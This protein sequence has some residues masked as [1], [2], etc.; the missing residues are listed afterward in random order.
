VHVA[1]FP[2]GQMPLYR[3]ADRL[4]AISRAVADAIVAQAP[5][6]ADRVVTIGYPVPDAY[7]CAEP[8]RQRTNTVLYVGRI[9]R[10][11]GLHVLVRAFAVAAAA[12]P[13][14]TDWKLRIIGPHEVAQGGDGPA[15]LGELRA[16]AQTLGGAC[17]FVGPVFDPDALV[18]EY[19]A[20]AVFAYPSL[21]EKGEAFG[22]A[23]L[24]AMA[25]GCAVVVSRLTCFDDFID[26][27]RSGLQF[28]HRSATA[29]AHRA[30]R[31][32]R[33]RTVPHA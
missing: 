15:Y 21:A 32:R 19:R 3:R 23:A 31:A 10:E 1:R 17:E 33:G 20:A 13:G 25:A 11:K 16:L 24:E 5:R 6:L 28:D 29:H 14:G 4:Q 22:L 9:A 26:A 18:D 27:G 7:F 2:K 30:M 12:R 8:A